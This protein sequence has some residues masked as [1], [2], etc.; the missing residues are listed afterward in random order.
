MSRCQH[1]FIQTNNHGHPRLQQ[2]VQSKLLKKQLLHKYQYSSTVTKWLT[3]LQP[4]YAPVTFSSTDE[5]GMW[6]N[7]KGISIQAGQHITG[8]SNIAVYVSG[9]NVISSLQC[10]AT[11]QLYQTVFYPY[12]LHTIVHNAHILF[13]I[14]IPMK[15]T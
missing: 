5:T 6:H 13:L 7:L 10:I 8:F 2:Y 4:D 12:L 1:N 15:I 9:A 11:R 14:F 3:L